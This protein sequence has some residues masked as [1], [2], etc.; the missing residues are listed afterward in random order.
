M[1]CQISM[2]MWN[3]GLHPRWQDK[4]TLINR[5]QISVGDILMVDLGLCYAPELSYG[6]SAY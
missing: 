6:F 4:K 3:S 1:R 5:Q 2:Q